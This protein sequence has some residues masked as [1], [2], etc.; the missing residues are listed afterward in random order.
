MLLLSAALAAP[1]GSGDH[2]LLAP[3]KRLYGQPSEQGSKSHD[4][5]SVPVPLRVDGVQGDWLQVRP[6]EDHCY[7]GIRDLDFVAWVRSEDLAQ[8][9]TAATTQTAGE[10]QV[11]L[12]PGLAV[13]EGHLVLPGLDLGPGYEGETSDHYTLQPEGLWSPVAVAT[14]GRVLGTYDGVPV[15][16][17]GLSVN[18][19]LSGEG[20]VM[21]VSDRCFQ[22]QLTPVPLVSWGGFSDRAPSP[23]DPVDLSEGD[24]LYDVYGEVVGSVLRDTRVAG[25]RDRP[26]CT[27]PFG[28]DL[29]F[30]EP[31][32]VV[33]RDDVSLR[34]SPRDTVGVRYGRGQAYMAM[35]LVGRQGEFVQV[36]FPERPIEHCHGVRGLPAGVAFW[37][38]QEDLQAVTTTSSTLFRPGAVITAEHVDSGRMLFP[39]VFPTDAGIIYRPDPRIPPPADLSLVAD[40]EGWLGDYE[41]TEVLI[42]RGDQVA[43]VQLDRRVVRAQDRCASVELKTWKSQIRPFYEP[44]FPDPQLPLTGMSKRV[45]VGTKLYFVEGTPAGRA[46]TELRIQE[47]EGPCGT[48]VVGEDTIRVCW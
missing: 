13:V 35:Q 30:C 48:L 31:G 37:V 5:S 3:R 24:L 27:A 11:Q 45:A 36:A 32:Y 42:A 17:A 9:T 2:V 43:A 44:E 12:A 25:A 26:D 10:D 1:V 21:V 28:G 7:R 8:V 18:L 46:R 40:D 19:T 23:D 41:G 20:E 39:E 16:R 29:L 4:W 47:V 33:V 22:V 15:S 34:T 6:V 38:R 14:T